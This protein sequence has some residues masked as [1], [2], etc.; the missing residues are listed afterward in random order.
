M[1]TCRDLCAQETHNTTHR[2]KPKLSKSCC[3]TAPVVALFQDA[4]PSLAESI[5][6]AFVDSNSLM[7]FLSLRSLYTIAIL[8]KFKELLPRTLWESDDN[9]P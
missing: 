6:H 7:G 5:G 9:V 3:C 2:C 4:S 8:S 1:A